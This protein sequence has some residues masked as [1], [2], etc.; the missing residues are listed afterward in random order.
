MMTGSAFHDVN[1]GHQFFGKL[2]KETKGAKA[3][4]GS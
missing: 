1:R 3:K 2:V 4:E